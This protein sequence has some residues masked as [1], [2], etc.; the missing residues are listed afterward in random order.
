VDEFGKILIQLQL[1]FG[2]VSYMKSSR[3]VPKLYKYSPKSSKTD[4]QALGEESEFR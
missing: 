2:L 1:D 4:T 3:V